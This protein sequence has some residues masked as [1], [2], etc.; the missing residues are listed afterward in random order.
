V[1]SCL[2]SNCNEAFTHSGGPLSQTVSDCVMLDNV[3]GDVVAPANCVSI[4]NR[5]WF[6]GKATASQYKFSETTSNTT[7][8]YCLFDMSRN[9]GQSQAQF[10]VSDG[11]TYMNNCTFYGGPSQIG[12]FTVNST[13]G[14]TATNCIFNSLWRVAF[15]TAPGT[16][17]LDH[18]ILSSFVITNWTSM[19]AS[20]STNAPLFSNAAGADYSLASGA[21]AIGAGV[22]VGLSLDLNNKRVGNPPSLGAYEFLTYATNSLVNAVIRNGKM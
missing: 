21:P 4:F 3:A 1:Q 2:I 20:V 9:T 13:A 19:M 10:T 15:I 8:N 11:Q 6:K 14:L 18:C 5:C 22:N 12:A 7:Y 16:F 17:A